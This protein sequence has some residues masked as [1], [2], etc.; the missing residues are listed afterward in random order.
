MGQAGRA[1]YDRTLKPLHGFVLRK[2]FGALLSAGLPARPVFFKQLLNVFVGVRN[3]PPSDESEVDAVVR[4]EMRRVL[5]FVVFRDENRVLLAIC[6]RVP[7]TRNF[8]THEGV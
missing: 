5:G 8:V 3:N 2:T 1:G 4:A 7:S 6:I